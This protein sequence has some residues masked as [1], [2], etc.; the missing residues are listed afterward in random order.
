[1][2]VVETGITPGIN[3]AIVSKE[4]GV[5]MIGAGLSRVPFEAFA[6]ALKALDQYIT[7]QENRHA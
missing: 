1:M 5:G 3:T 2:K 6:K 4:P 7:G